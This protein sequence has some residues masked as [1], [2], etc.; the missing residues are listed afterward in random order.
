[1][2]INLS[3]EYALLGLIYLGK[4]PDRSVKISEIAKEE[5]IPLAFL[6]KV[7]QDL[8]KSKIV[9]STFGPNGGYRLAMPAEKITMGKI[10]SI[11]RPI[12]NRRYAYFSKELLKHPD[13]KLLSDFFT[14]FHE[15][16]SRHLE[17]ILLKQ[18]IDNKKI[19]LIK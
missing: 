14:S 5:K 15:E 7:F 17:N 19:K 11:L 3:I 16:I 2:F 1:M 9:V 12:I 10:F 6:Q 8:S 18:I 4:N 13:G